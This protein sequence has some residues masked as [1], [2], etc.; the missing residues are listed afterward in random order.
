M[1]DWMPIESAPK[2]NQ[3]VLLIAANTPI[4]MY[5]G[6]YRLGFWGEPQQDYLAWRC[7]SS[8]KFA[9]PTHWMPLPQPPKEQSCSTT[10][11]SGLRTS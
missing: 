2:G 3:S 4:P 10:S 11:D 9:T 8:G 1:S 7:D 5:C 6:R